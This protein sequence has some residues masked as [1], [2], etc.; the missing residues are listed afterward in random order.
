MPSLKYDGLSDQDIIVIYYRTNALQHYV[1]E[2][3]SLWI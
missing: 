1:C 3:T 2:Q